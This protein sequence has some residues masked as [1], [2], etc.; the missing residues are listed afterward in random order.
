MDDLR[1]AVAE[2]IKRLRVSRGFT[3]AQLAEC[4][5]RSLDMVS[6]LERGDATPSLETIALLAQ[7]LETH[8]S[9]LLGGAVMPDEISPAAQ[10]LIQRLKWSSDDDLAW[11]MKLLDLVER[12]P[13]T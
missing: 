1:A 12:R 2:S 11:I 3:Q 7:A 9:H 8:P 10:Q 13:A 4:I 6:R 5:G